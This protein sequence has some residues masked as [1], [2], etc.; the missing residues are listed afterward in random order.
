MLSPAQ[1]VDSDIAVI[2]AGDNKVRVGGADV[3][4]EHPTGGQAG[5]LRVGRVLQ[6][7]HGKS[8]LYF[9]NLLLYV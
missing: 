5:V 8:K 2:E 1:I 3:E 7:D 6:A 4:G 9:Q